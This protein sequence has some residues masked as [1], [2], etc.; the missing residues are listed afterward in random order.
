M[1]NTNFTFTERTI[2]DLT[3]ILY[4]R[5]GDRCQFVNKT[6]T[7]SSL[8]RRPKRSQRVLCHLLTDSQAEFERIEAVYLDV[9]FGSQRL[10]TY[11]P[12]PTLQT[13]S[14]VRFD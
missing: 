11:K 8:L 9:V 1:E 14:A 10:L 13:E 12:I 6:I 2:S 3:I 7:A 5:S 4:G